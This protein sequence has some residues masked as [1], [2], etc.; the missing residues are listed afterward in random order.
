[1]RVLV[2]NS[3]ADLANAVSRTLVDAAVERLERTNPGLAVVRRDVAAQPIPHL[4][5]ETIEGVRGEIA[6]TLSEVAAR[7]LSDELIEELRETDIV[8]IGAPMYNFSVP[9]VLR[10]WFDHVLRPGETFRYTESG[11]LGLLDGKRVLVVESRGGFYSEATGKAGD[12]QAPYLRHLLGFIGLR[13]VTFVRAE[14]IGFGPDAREAAITTA[15]TE[16][17]GWVADIALAKAA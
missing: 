9:T 12:F 15:L 17:D 1:M 10:A 2:I 13:D 14:K 8:V 5:P 4:V 6:R 7:K 3:S 11:P 16:I